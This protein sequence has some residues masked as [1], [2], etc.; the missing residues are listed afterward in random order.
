V[1]KIAILLTA[2]NGENWIR[3]QLKTILLQKDVEIDLYVSLDLST[4]K[5]KEIIVEFQKFNQNIFLLKYG[6]KFGGA[7][8]NFFRL[9]KDVELSS[10]DFVSLSDQDD[11]W[12]SEKLIN[13]IKIMNSNKFDGYSSNVIAFWENGNKKLIQKAFP[14]KKFDFMFESGGPGCTYI[15]RSNLVSDFKLFLIQNWS[16]INKIEL[17]DWFIYAFSRSRKYKWHID[18]NPTMLYRQHKHN[19]FGAN[20][21]LKSYII[22]LKKI[23]NGWY[24]CEVNKISNLLSLPEPT[25]KFIILN[26]FSLRR[27]TI[28]NFY[29]LI[30]SFFIKRN[31]NTF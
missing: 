27:R 17:H 2:Y 10:Y 22:R 1:P 25:F 23:L 31:Q 26:L 7:A 24:F 30:F 15:L 14:Q 28:E 29:I 4:D 21:S 3:E 16:E 11:I 6:E 19:Q 13:G 18:K 20:I 5:T 9:F 12:L 8:K